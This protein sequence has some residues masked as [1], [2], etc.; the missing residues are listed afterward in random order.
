LKEHEKWK[1]DLLNEI[2]FQQKIIKTDKGKYLITAL[3]FYNYN[4]E[5][6]FKST[7]EKI[8]NR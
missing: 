8:F 7:L 3:P 2:R 6:E 5:N 4:N 1:E